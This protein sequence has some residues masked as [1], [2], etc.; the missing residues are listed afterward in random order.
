VSVRSSAISPLH[1]RNSGG[2]LLPICV[3]VTFGARAARGEKKF[4]FVYL[5]GFGAAGAQFD[6]ETRIYISTRAYYTRLI[7]HQFVF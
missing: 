5:N 4:P 1:A 6:F 2:A 3:C 7:G